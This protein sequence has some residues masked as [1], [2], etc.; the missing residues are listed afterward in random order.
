MRLL[1][2]MAWRNIWRNKRRTFITISSIVL[3]MVLSVIMRSMQLGSYSKMIDDVVGTYSGH[4]Q[5]HAKGYWADK[6]INNAFELPDTVKN[7]ILQQPNVA[8]LIPRLE[9]F[10]LAAGKERSH[11]SFVVG[12]SPDKETHMTRLREKLVKGT[13]FDASGKGALVA[14]GLASFL[15]LDIGDSIVLLGQGYHGINA[16]GAFP[17]TGI[18]KFSAPEI[19]RS[20]VYL[21]LKSA[22][23]MF[24]AENLLTSVVVNLTNT[25]R[26]KETMINLTAAV[27]TTVY[28]ILDW[29]KLLPELVQQIQGDNSGGM[30]MLGILYLIVAFGI[31]GTILMMTTERMRE[32]GVVNALGLGRMKLSIMVTFE[33][34]LLAVVSIVAGSLLSLPVIIH[35]HNHPIRL[36]GEAAKGMINFGVEPVLPFLLDPAIFLHQALLILVITFISTIYPLLVLKN[37]KPVAAMRT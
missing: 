8:D 13:Y 34:T 28:E 23:Q 1:L 31:F 4:L 32:F 29:K 21:D 2:Q 30:I 22:Q 36:T 7:K 3:A 33:T 24:S 5:L 27:D 25:R 15:S 6:S 12:I 16:A 35:F 20:F 26:V 10:A 9:S 17:V 19:N 18:V 14:Q 37:L 11:G